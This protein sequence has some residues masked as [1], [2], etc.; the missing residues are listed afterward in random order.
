MSQNLLE[1]WVPLDS[2]AHFSF[3]PWLTGRAWATDLAAPCGSLDEACPPQ[4]Q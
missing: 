1:F 3:S 2:Q 4:F